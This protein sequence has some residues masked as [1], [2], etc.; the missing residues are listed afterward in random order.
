MKTFFANKYVL[1]G[2]FA[3]VGLFLGW[4]IFHSP[5]GEP[6]S[7]HLAEAADAS[8]RWTCSMHPQIRMD[9][10]GKCPICAMDLIA[11]SRS[12]QPVDSD[13]IHLTKEAAAL[14][15]VLTS[16]VEHS[17]PTQNLRLYGKVKTDERKLQSQV[18]H[19]AGRIEQLQVNYTGEAVSQGQTLA[20]L[21]SPQLVTAQQELLEAASSKASQPDIYEAIKEKLRQLKLTPQQIERIEKTGQV[22]STIELVSNTAGIVTAMQVSKGDYVTAGTVL[23]QIAD[24]SNLWVQFD[25]YESDLPYLSRGDELTFAVQAINGQHFTGRIAFIDPV[26]DPQTRTAKV[27]VEISNRGSKLKPEMFAT[28]TIEAQL[29]EYQ[30]NIVVPRS[31]V[32]WT[33]KRSIVYVRQ[34]D[35]AEPIFRL[36]EVELGP[37]LGDS[38]VIINGLTDGEEIVTQGAF[39][40]DAAAQLEGKPSMM[41]HP[42]AAIPQ[43]Q[44]PA[45]ND[46]ISKKYLSFAVQGLC[47]MCRERIEV[48]ALTV[49]GVNSA[50][51]NAE[52]KKLE[53][54]VTANAV[55]IIDIHRAVA[56]VGHDTELVK[57]DDNT[58]NALPDCCKYR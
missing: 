19:I 23:Y 43:E 35:T 56:A 42:E 33:G 29:K 39:S 30:G 31:A 14:A 20:I 58:Y 47:D 55:K 41:N 50:K 37:M 5:K 45:K 2:I 48:A 24:L 26:I 11:V 49:K 40:I 51:W 9:A 32:L 4:L 27:R 15:N 52:S 6:E 8:Q 36:R 25:A 54:I 28:A 3:L 57:A 46:P 10:P 44:I 1:A 18:A 34:P 13:A 21:Y 12:S 22:Q 53:V 17:N 16:R 7:V 38:Y